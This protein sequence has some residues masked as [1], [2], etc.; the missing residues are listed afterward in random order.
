M[1]AALYLSLG[2]GIEENLRE[3][4]TAFLRLGAVLGQQL[5]QRIGDGD[6]DGDLYLIG[7]LA[8]DI[9]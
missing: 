9:G 8:A 3:D 2:G 1:R 6:V 5:L 4:A 7:N